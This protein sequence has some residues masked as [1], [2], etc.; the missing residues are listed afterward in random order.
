[1]GTTHA[2]SSRPG[3][4][5]AAQDADDPHDGDG[6][7]GDHDRFPGQ[8]AVGQERAG[9]HGAPGPDREQP[10]QQAD[11]GER[12]RG[13]PGQAGDETEVSG[14]QQPGQRVP[15]ALDG[16][17]GAQV[18]QGADGG[19]VDG[20]QHDRDQGVLAEREQP[21]ERGIADPHVAVGPVHGDAVR[22]VVEVERI[23]RQPV[24]ELPVVAVGRCHRHAM[25]Q[26]SRVGEMPADQDEPADVAVRPGLP[27]GQGEGE[28]G[29]RG[30]QAGQR[31]PVRSRRQ[32]AGRR[33][34]CP[35]VRAVAGDGRNSGRPTGS[36]AVRHDRLRDPRTGR[37]VLLTRHGAF[38]VKGGPGQE[39]PPCFKSRREPTVSDACSPVKI[40]I[41]RARFGEI[42]VNGPHDE[43]ERLRRQGDN[44]TRSQ[45]GHGGKVKRQR[46]DGGALPVLS[47]AP[48]GLPRSAGGIHGDQFA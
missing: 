35:A 7:H 47:R 25:R 29:E 34:A 19:D 10:G 39:T 27:A 28:R 3:P 8:R 44:K 43:P 31:R 13:V 24:E 21:G 6:G 36:G 45:A 33:R 41:R 9:Q 16:E 23:D 40:P 15:S 1:M 32:R 12:L 2:R 30:D 4:C 22:R 5:L 46:R 48:G 38:L 42:T 11:G 37:Q 18:A 14:Q 26:L 20:D 17:H